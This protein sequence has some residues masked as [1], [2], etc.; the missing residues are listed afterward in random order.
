MGCRGTT[1]DILN[2]MARQAQRTNDTG[3]QTGSRA[4]PR[5]DKEARKADYMRAAAK[6]F[7]AKG[8]SASMQDVAD[9]A[10]A[11]KPVFYRIFPSRADLIDSFFQYIHDV[12]VQTQR[13]EWDGYG[14]ALRVL[15]LEAKK[16]PEIF[17]VALK[18]FRG[19]PALE[20]L[21]EKLLGLIHAQAAGFYQPAPGAPHGAADRVAKASKTMNSL[22]FDTLVA[23]LEDSDGLS[24]EKRFVWYGRIIRE[25]RRATREAFEL[26]SPEAGEKSD[27]SDRKA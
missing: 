9:A 15:Y 1:G 24:D 8:A 23:W 11:P 27:K 16:E 2:T 5:V 3:P 13:G 18:T 21:R 7:L 22:A 6:A 19:D 20:P 14:W 26:D 10:G 12:I 17:L 25:W 4:K